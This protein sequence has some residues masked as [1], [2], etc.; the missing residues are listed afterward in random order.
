M[1]RGEVPWMFEEA[2]FKASFVRPERMPEIKDNAEN[3]EIRGRKERKNREKGVGRGEVPGGCLRKPC[4][5]QAWEDE[6]ATPLL[7]DHL[8]ITVL[9]S[10]RP[11]NLA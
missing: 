3:R 11:S 8:F 1:G 10:F 4:L 6:R 5:Q 7:R 9:F 2:M